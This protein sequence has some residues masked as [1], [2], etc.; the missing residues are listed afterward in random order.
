MLLKLHFM[1]IFTLICFCL[2]NIVSPIQGQGV[3]HAKLF[4]GKFSG[5]D[6]SS[7]SNNFSPT[8]NLW[9]LFMIVLLQLFLEEIL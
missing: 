7:F 8:T 2:F 9:N 6:S 5:N 4:S 3:D 1:W